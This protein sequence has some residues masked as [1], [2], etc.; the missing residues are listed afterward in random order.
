MHACDVQ[1]TMLSE[2][3]GR[4]ARPLAA[5][6]AAAGGDATSDAVVAQLRARCEQ[7][8]QKCHLYEHEVSRLNDKL[9]RFI[10]QVLFVVCF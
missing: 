3:V 6:A 2:D 8:S 9:E 5:A 10:H 4:S 1:R 7:L